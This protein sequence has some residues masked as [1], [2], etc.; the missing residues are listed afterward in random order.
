M[1]TYRIPAPLKLRVIRETMYRVS[2]EELETR[3]EQIEALLDET[4]HELDRTR[5]QCRSMRIIAC[6][7][8]LGGTWLALMAYARLP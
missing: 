1:T 7:Y 6:L 4:R 3:V 5:R 2:K 8:M